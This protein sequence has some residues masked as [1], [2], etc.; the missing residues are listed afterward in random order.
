MI[1]RANFLL[2]LRK[3]I[4]CDTSFESSSRDGSDEGSQ[5]IVSMRNKKN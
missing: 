5:D 4:C 2:I 3:N 1:I